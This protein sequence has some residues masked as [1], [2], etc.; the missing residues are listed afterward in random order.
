[1]TTHI[2]LS[3]PSRF[4]AF[5]TI[6]LCLLAGATCMSF[7]GC[8][9]DTES[10]TSPVDE[11]TSS[12]SNEVVES[13]DGSAL[14]LTSSS[15]SESSS[16]EKAI[17]VSSSS[18]GKNSSSSG[19][20]ES[21]SSDKGEKS[22]SSE[23]AAGSSSAKVEDSSSSAKVD[24]SSSSVKS[25]ESSSS[26]KVEES[27]SSEKNEISSSSEKPV[28]S[29]SSE[30][31]EESSSSEKSSS[32]AGIP[33]KLYDCEI[34]K[35]VTTTHLNPN[36]DYGE[37]LDVRDSQ[38]YRTV[39]IGEQ[40]WM[41]QNLNWNTKGSYCLANDSLNCKSKGHMYPWS[42]AQSACPDG[43]HLPDTA[44]FAYLKFYVKQNNGGIGVGTSLKKG[45]ND[46]FGFSSLVN[47]GYQ[48]GSNGQFSESDK[49]FYWTNSEDADNKIY[50][51][52]RYL[53]NSSENLCYETFRKTWSLSVRCIKD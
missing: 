1:M 48:T 14:L 21:S 30:K 18:D 37:Y 40:V 52:V 11:I 12:T 50:A 39:Q 4:S 5:K 29:S 33:S 32:S 53:K 9:G 19:N 28:E 17:D 36:I 42:I 31:V 34:Y 7:V 38:V 16:S 23:G 3:R 13:S 51:H 43:W 45:A 49:M 15:E 47:G 46:I 27:S 24:E 6:I 10:S 44:D 2:H 20:V 26:V 8:G 25:A 35:C 22:S 41:A